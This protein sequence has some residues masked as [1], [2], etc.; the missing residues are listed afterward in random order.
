MMFTPTPE[1]KKWVALDA[2]N[3]YIWYI[4]HI[5]TTTNVHSVLISGLMYQGEVLK[6]EVAIL[7]AVDR[8]TSSKA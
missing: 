4:K 2:K 8:S 7:H 6:D 3:R 1:E 5:A